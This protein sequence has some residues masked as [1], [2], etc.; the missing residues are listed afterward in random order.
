MTR[1]YRI[2]LASGADLQALPDIERAAA[3]LFPA[4]RIPDPDDVMPLLEL[5]KACDLGML[6]LVSLV[7]EIAGFAMASEHERSLHIDVMAVHPDHGRR[8]VGKRLIRAI[9]E[10]ARC[11]GLPVVTLTTFR[12]LPWNAP[13]YE[14]VGFQIVD[15]RT[16]SPMLRA[17]LAQE[18]NIGLTDRLAMMCTLGD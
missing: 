12:D 10:R 6:Y 1:P 18:A 17:T 2:R 16:L 4:G 14:K 15:D 8:G 3:T 13:F 11:R 7:D 5:E 9:I